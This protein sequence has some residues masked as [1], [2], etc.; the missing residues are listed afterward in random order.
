MRD[1]ASGGP[2]GRPGLAVAAPLG[3]EHLVSQ[4]VLEVL[5][6]LQEEWRR[7]RPASANGD[8]R[9]VAIVGTLAGHQHHLGA[10]CVRNCLERAGWKTFHLGPDVPMEEFAQ[11]Q[12][13][14]EAGL[15]CIS[16][17]PGGR[18][19]EAARTVGGS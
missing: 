12:K 13:S 2:E 6:G 10:L 11:V 16:L 7:N 1:D 18:L 3:D 17:A 14:R 15:V 4:V 9:T 5:M 8:A 19:G